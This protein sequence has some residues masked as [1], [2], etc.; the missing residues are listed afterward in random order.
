MNLPMHWRDKGKRDRPKLAT[1][2]KETNGKTPNTISYADFEAAFLTWLDELDWASV[3]DAADSEEIKAFEAKVGSLD[4][5]ISRDSQ[6]V[7]TII[8]ALVDLPSPALK[9]RL[10]ATESAL[11][12][13]KSERE[14]AATLNGPPR[15]P[16]TPC[17]CCI[18]FTGKW[19]IRKWRSVRRFHLHPQAKVFFGTIE[20]GRAFLSGLP[21]STKQKALRHQSDTKAP[22]KRGGEIPD[23]SNREARIY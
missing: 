6:R 18:S 22:R 17:K 1:Y 8:D 20:W 10:A 3:I 23:S 2:S 21:P 14:E 4:L 11:V 7:E 9:A 16:T 12:A 13:A 5:A 19:S 15:R